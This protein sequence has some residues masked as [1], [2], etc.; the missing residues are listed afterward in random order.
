MWFYGLFAAQVAKEKSWHS[1][2]DM[3]LDRGK[4]R[5][6]QMQATLF[7]IKYVARHVKKKTLNGTPWFVHLCECYPEMQFFYTTSPE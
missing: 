1:L 2:W 5:T 4:H 3:A 6:W 7:S